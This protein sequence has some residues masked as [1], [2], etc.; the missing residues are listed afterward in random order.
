[1]FQKPF[2]LVVLILVVLLTGAGLIL[3]LSGLASVLIPTETNG[4]FAIAGGFSINVLKLILIV[5]LFLIAFVVFR[6]LRPR[7]R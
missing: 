6:F 2:Q 5:V 4:V 7:L 3:L 1:M